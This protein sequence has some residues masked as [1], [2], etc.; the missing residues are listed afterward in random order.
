MKS[1][2]NQFPIFRKYPDLIYLD[3]GATTFKPQVVIDKEMEYYSE[4]CANIHRGMYEIALKADEE[5]EK[6]RVNVAR[7]IGAKSSKE[8]IFVS[9][10]TMGINMLAKSIGKA[11]LHRG[12]NVLVTEMEHHS[13]LVPWQMIC[14]E[15]RAQLRWLTFSR[16]GALVASEADL[17][18]VINKKTKI[19]S[20]THV[21][22]V[23][24]TINDIKKMVRMVKKINPSC[25][26][27]VD[28]AQSV[29]HIPIDV[30]ELGCD[31]LTFSAHKL[32]GPTGVGVAWGK[33]ELL[34]ELAPFMG[35]GDMVMDVVMG[36]STYKELPMRLEAGTPN[37]AGVIGMGVAVEWLG[38]L[39]AGMEHVREHEREM[40]E[41]ALGG[42]NKTEGIEIYGPMSAGERGGL[43][44]FNLK[45]VHPHDVAQVLADMDI[46]VRA[47]HHC[48]MPLHKKL[49][50]GGSVRASFGVY[51]E[52]S[53]IDKLIEGLKIARKKF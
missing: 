53:D 47:G 8:V 38:K 37:I 19:F 31:F 20:L 51:T 7:F 9:G 2:K 45:G 30:Y 44:A 36:E 41:Y 13:N 11:K 14:A 29:A 22:N 32:Y 4:Y 15:N 6:A 35:G 16:G 24:G 33:E 48:A 23:L 1:I 50:I 17:E 21:S 5:Y 18:K 12:D 25:V 34:S 27:V 42:L 28:A 3:S 10:T 40:T 46:C 26:I 49:N 39:P 43:V 52:K